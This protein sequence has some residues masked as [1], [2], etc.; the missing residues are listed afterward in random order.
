MIETT[1]NV[2]GGVRCVKLE[3]LADYFLHKH[4]F[5]SIRMEHMLT[6]GADLCLCMNG[7]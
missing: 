4:K 6:F 5:R 3:T 2:S 7:L 1:T